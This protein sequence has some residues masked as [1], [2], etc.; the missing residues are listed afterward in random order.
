MLNEETNGKLRDGA[1]IHQ[2]KGVE[3]MDVGVEGG[4]ARRSE[5][6]E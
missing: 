3:T 2:A 1:E 6:M 5:M 4:Q